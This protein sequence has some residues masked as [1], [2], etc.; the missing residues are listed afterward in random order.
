MVI[1]ERGFVRSGELVFGPGEKV[2]LLEAEEKRLVEL[3]IA[4]IVKDG[5]YLVSVNPVEAALSVED[6]NPDSEEIGESVVATFDENGL[7]ESMDKSK[8]ARK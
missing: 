7:E 2:T 3:G 8:R 1:I 5:D 4:S 6:M